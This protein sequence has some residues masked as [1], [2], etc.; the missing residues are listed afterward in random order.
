MNASMPSE[1][2]SCPGFYTYQL[3][4]LRLLK[5]PLGFN[6]IVYVK[7]LS[8]PGVAHRIL[9]ATGRVSGW[10]VL[11]CTAQQGLA[12][13]E[14]CVSSPEL[15]APSLPPRI[16][17]PVNLSFVRGRSCI[18][19][20]LPWPPPFLPTPT[21]ATLLSSEPSC[22]GLEAP[23][24]DLVPLMSCPHV[25]KPQAMLLLSLAP[26]PASCRYCVSGFFSLVLQS[27]SSS[28]PQRSPH[29]CRRPPQP[30]S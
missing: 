14:G 11:P 4:S 2:S 28:C 26:I 15:V 22:F 8:A 13:R 12:P 20:F 5:D 29:L 23:P 1:L 18:S 3:Q 10:R 16:A 6:E 21:A 19:S 7:P 24:V 30:A 27:L 25:P 17:G 9:V